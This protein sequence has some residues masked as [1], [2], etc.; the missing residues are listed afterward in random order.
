M[1]LITLLILCHTTSTVKHSEALKFYVMVSSGV[2]KVPGYVAMGALDGVIMGYYDSSMETAEPKEDW[3]RKVTRDDPEMWEMQVQ[4]CRQYE[5]IFKDETFIFMHHSNQ[6]GG[7][8]IVQQLMGCEW[9]DVTEQPA[10]FKRYGYNGDDFLALNMD[11]ETWTTANPQA[12]ISKQ[13]WNKNKDNS[14]FW[15]NFLVMVCPSWLK[16]Y[17]NFGK[18][19]VHRRDLPTVS[20]LQKSPSSPVSC[21]ATGFYPDKAVMFWSRFDCV[22]QLSDVKDDIIIKLDKAQIR[23]NWGKP[24]NTYNEGESSDMNVP[25]IAAVVV[26]VVIISAAVGFA[27]YKS[28]KENAPRPSAD[29]TELSETLNPTTKSTHTSCTQ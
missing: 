26:L 27:V 15:K 9:D 16:M 4:Y 3:V 11:T 7:V 22:F 24:Q 23:R 1:R 5:Q 17:L 20:L 18:S 28:K 29:N 13:E 10:G 21:H 6:T 12:E 25:I 8:H 14:R 19:S 2:P